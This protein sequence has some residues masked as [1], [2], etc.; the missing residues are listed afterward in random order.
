MSCNL[1]T[2]TLKKFQFEILSIHG[3]MGMLNVWLSFLIPKST[4]CSK[5]VQTIALRPEC[6][7]MLKCGLSWAAVEDAAVSL[8]H[9]DNHPAELCCSLSA[10][11][12][13]THTDC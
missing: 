7:L 4:I 1:N 9:K 12:P 13:F 11:A 6:T 5:P 3:W 10:T 2:V 8:D